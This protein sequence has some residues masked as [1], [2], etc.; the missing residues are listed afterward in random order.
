MV[1]AVYLMVDAAVA[2]LRTTSLGELGKS[3]ALESKPDSFWLQSLLGWAR[4]DILSA[5][6][7]V[8]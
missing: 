7:E 6:G 4:F 5:R 2:N 3:H 1:G 8:E